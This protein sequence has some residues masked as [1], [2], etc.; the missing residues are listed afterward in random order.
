MRQYQVRSAALVN[1]A[2]KGTAEVACLLSVDLEMDGLKQN[3][4]ILDVAALLAVDEEIL[5]MANRNKHEEELHDIYELYEMDLRVG[6]ADSSR[7]YNVP[8]RVRIGPHS[9]QP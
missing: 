1:A 2:C 3:C 4:G 9:S 7:E 5:A 6:G 8:V